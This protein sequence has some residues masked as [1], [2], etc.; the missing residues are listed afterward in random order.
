MTYFINDNH[1]LVSGQVGGAL[2]AHESFTD[3]YFETDDEGN[4]TGRTIIT[5]PSGT[6]AVKVEPLEL[7][8]GHE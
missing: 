5:R 1:A 8:D 7:G 4:Y 6:W 2:M 3:V